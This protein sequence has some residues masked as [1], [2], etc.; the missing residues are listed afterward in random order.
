MNQTGVVSFFLNEIKT[1]KEMNKPQFTFN[2]K[3]LVT[4]LLHFHISS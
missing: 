4:E 3:Q 2:D 1:Y